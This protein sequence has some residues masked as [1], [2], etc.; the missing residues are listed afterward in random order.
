MAA[1]VGQ[2]AARRRV[3]DNAGPE[4]GRTGEV[5]SR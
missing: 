2:A 3:D 5:F 1:A 4:E